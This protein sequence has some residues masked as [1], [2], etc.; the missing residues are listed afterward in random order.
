MSANTLYIP[1]HVGLV[2]QLPPDIQVTVADP[3]R[4]YPLSQL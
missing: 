2:L 3:D 4:L 1:V